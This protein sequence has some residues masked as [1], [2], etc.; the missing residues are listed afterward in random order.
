MSQQATVLYDAPGPRART[1]NMITTVVFLAVLAAVIVYIVMALNDNGQLT[2]E[3]WEPFTQAG[4]WTT[5]IL[6]GILG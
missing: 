4:T 1:R 5:W 2:S 6:P 3:K